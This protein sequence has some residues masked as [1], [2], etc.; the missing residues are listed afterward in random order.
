VP[1]AAE[2]TAQSAAEIE[3]AAAAANP[4]LLGLPTFIVGAVAL[5]LFLVG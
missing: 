3:A 1:S 2:A 4:A 5:G